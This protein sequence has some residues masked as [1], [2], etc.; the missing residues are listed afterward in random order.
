MNTRRQFLKPTL[1][2]VRARVMVSATDWTS[3]GWG[4]SFWRNISDPLPLNRWMQHRVLEDTETGSF[5]DLCVLLNSG[6]KNR[7]GDLAQRLG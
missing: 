7:S 3:I 6:L 4:V 5:P 1:F 2:V